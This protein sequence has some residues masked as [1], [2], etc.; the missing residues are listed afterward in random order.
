[1]G[2]SLAELK[3]NSKQN[4]ERLIQESEKMTAKKTFPKDE[5]FWQPT[6]DK[7]GNGFALIRF[8][9]TPAADGD[10]GLPWVRYYEH[11][12]KGPTGKWYIE[13]SLTSIGQDDPVGAYNSQLWESG[14]KRLIEQARNQKRKL[15][16]VSNILVINDPANPENNGKVFLYRYGQ[17]IHDK[18]MNVMSPDSTL[19]DQ[20]NDP[21]DFWNGQNFK[22]KV[23]RV[24]EF[25]NYDDSSFSNPT[26]VAGNDKEIDRIWKSEHSLKE[27]TDPANY[28]S[29]DELNKKFQSVLGIR[30]EGVA[31]A[32]E[33]LSVEADNDLDM[34][35]PDVDS[36]SEDMSLDDILNDL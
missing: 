11:S 7:A 12:F 36:S 29:Y 27:F 8:L 2:L 1:M 22:L 20:P 19:G 17:K 16:F 34:N 10:D 35:V 4:L 31:M 3:K 33:R 23:K 9:P 18:I 28:K 14:D 13:K 25:P 6:L 15:R 24:A 5:R 21:F 32:A 26:P 30:S